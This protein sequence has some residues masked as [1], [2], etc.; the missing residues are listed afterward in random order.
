MFLRDLGVPEA[1]LLLDTRALTTH[2]NAVNVRRILAERGMQR[3]LLVTSAMHMR[4]SEAAFRAVGLDPIPV[5]TD[6]SVSSNPV[7]GPRRYLPSA[8]AL[9]ASTS[10][11]H[12]YLGYLFYRLRGWI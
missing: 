1:A 12:E 6:F 4:R 10:V 8:Q 2:E 5:A 9:A 3:F 11:V 7:I